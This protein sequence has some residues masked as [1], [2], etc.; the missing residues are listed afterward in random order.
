VNDLLKNT[1]LILG[2]RIKKIKFD[3][4]FTKLYRYIYDLRYISKNQGNTPLE[5]WRK[6]LSKIENLNYLCPYLETVEKG[7]KDSF[8]DVFYIDQFHIEL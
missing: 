1:E 4:Q 7:W 2:Y 3:Q 6:H 8:E 5:Y